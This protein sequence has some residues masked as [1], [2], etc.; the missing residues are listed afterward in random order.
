MPLSIVERIVL[1]RA[2]KLE[3]MDLQLIFER[4]SRQPVKRLKL[5]S[6]PREVKVYRSFDEDDSAVE[7]ALLALDSI[8]TIEASSTIL[9]AKCF[10]SILR[11]GMKSSVASPFVVNLHVGYYNFSQEQIAAF[12]KVMKHSTGLRSLRTGFW[13]FYSYN[14]SKDSQFDVSCASLLFSLGSGSIQHLDFPMAPPNIV[15]S[16]CLAKSLKAMQENKKS[17]EST[18]TT[19]RLTFLGTPMKVPMKSYLTS[20]L[21][22]HTKNEIKLSLSGRKDVLNSYGDTEFLS[23]LFF[24]GR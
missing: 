3:P 18:I 12:S 14:V 17:E 8:E 5:L 20:L 11:K 24:E 13:H 19:I 1:S 21:S 23:K 7:D 22:M 15:F 4:L 9:R 10:L 2:V 16:Y 6:I